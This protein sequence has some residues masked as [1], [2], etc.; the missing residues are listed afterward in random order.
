M[1]T[2]IVELQAMFA[3]VKQSREKLRPIAADTARDPSVRRQIADFLVESED[4][5]NY[6]ATAIAE[7]AAIGTISCAGVSPAQ[8]SFSSLLH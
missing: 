8:E 5:M 7:Q 3:A 2:T 4:E 6:L 1:T